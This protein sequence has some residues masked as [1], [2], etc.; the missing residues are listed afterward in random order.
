[1]TFEH[2]ATAPRHHTELHRAGVWQRCEQQ[3]RVGR[4]MIKALNMVED[5]LFPHFFLQLGVLSI[6]SRQDFRGSRISD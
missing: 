4:C 6:L 1:M 5:S 3:Q 2:E